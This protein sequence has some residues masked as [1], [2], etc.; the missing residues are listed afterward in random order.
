MPALQLLQTRSPLNILSLPDELLVEIF[1][2]VKTCKPVYSV[3]H[4]SFAST[5]QDIAN[6]RLVCRRFTECSSHLL[7]HHVHLDGINPES[8]EKLEEISHHPVI[9]KGVQSVRLVT[10]FYTPIFANDLRRFAWFAL[11]KVFGQALQYKEAF[12][13]EESEVDL[14]DPID[15]ERVLQRKKECAAVMERV[16]AVLKT[17]SRVRGDET[18]NV[19]GSW[20]VDFEKSDR[21][22][23]ALQ[24]RNSGVKDEAE[25]ARHM[26][27]LHIAHGLYRLRY[28]KQ[29]KL[30][31]DDTFIR[32]FATAMARMP[33]AK[34]LEIHDF[35][36][37]HD[38]EQSGTYER[39]ILLD[40]EYDGL[41]D[42]DFLTQPMSWD[43]ATDRG[44]GDPPV[45]LLFRLPVAIQ[46]VGARLDRISMQ[47]STCAENYYP[48]LRKAGAQ[49]VIDLGRAV[50][51]MRLKK[52]VFVHQTEM[53][54]RVRH[55]PAP[56]D[57]EAFDSFITAMTNSGAL[58]RLWLRVDSGWSDGGLDTEGRFSHGSLFLSDPGALARW[59]QPL[60]HRLRDVHMSDLALHLSDLERLAAQLKEINIK[61]E[62]LTFQRIRLISGTWSEALEILRTVDVEYEKEIWEPKGAECEDVTMM[63]GGRYD[64]VFGKWGGTR[65]LADEFI[66][67]DMKHNPLRDNY[68]VE[69]IYSV[70]GE[71]VLVEVM[72]GDEFP[73]VMSENLPE[74]NEL[75]DEVLPPVL[76]QVISQVV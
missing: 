10:R 42:I 6:I 31:Q 4:G 57:M 2:A 22:Y 51:D 3:Q 1:D 62:F 66:N 11:N 20:T 38:T 61:L 5:A 26:Q 75:G 35:E 40:D 69:M 60:W 74:S 18:E 36:T 12:E 37:D 43:E 50:S 55:T 48:L 76:S 65:S 68:T 54:P 27:L 33:R 32:R 44:L 63:L 46:K 71:E 23:M 49:D 53:K 52:F 67:G 72:V 34:S 45:K 8:L 15:V 41:I 14:D 13:E 29:E 28:H 70:Y 58:E 25:E 56:V 39:D 7:V 59:G 30:R 47:T 73:R 24:R 9:G 19:T 21:E 16:K 17:W 64:V